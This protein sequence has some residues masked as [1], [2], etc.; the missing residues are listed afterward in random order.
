MGRGH[1]NASGDVSVEEFHAIFE[2]KIF[3]NR[4]SSA[5]FPL[6]VFVPCPI[7]CVLHEFNCVTADD[8]IAKVR[9]LPNSV[10]AIRFRRH[11]LRGMS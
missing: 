7:D 1:T 3:E 4:A 6:A 11:S 9:T 2:N 5:G 8:V 10:P